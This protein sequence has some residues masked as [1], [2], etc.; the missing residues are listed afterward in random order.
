MVYYVDSIYGRDENDGC[1]RQTAFRTVTRINSLTLQGGDSVL[2]KAGGVYPGSLIPRREPGE[3]TV[4]F[5]RY[6]VGAPPVIV[7]DTEA[8]VDLLDFAHVELRNLAVTNPQ[9]LYGVR[10]CN[11]AGGETAHVHILGCSIYNVYGGHDTFLIQTGGIVITSGREKPGWYRDLLI[12][13]NHVYD[14]CRTGIILITNWSNRPWKTWAENEYVSDTENWW[15]SY[16]VVFRGNLIERPAGDA[17]VLIG[18]IRP[19]MEWNT[20][21]HVMNDPKPHCANAGIWPQ[22]TEGCVVQYNEVGYAHK[23]AGCDDAQGF[24]VD[25]SC[26]DTLV[27]YNYSHDN[28]G[29]FLLL[30]ELQGTEPY[31]YRGTVVR[32]NLSVNDGNVKGELIALVGPV[33][34]VTIENNTLYASGNVE[35]IVEVW[36]GEGEEQAKDVTIRNNLF[37]SNGKNN[38]FHLAR[39]ENFHMENNLYWGTHATP[40]EGEKDAV[41]ADP[42][43]RL[44]GSAGEGRLCAEAYVPLPGSP[45]LAAELPPSRPAPHDFFGNPVQGQ[46]YIGAFLGGHRT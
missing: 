20:A 14:V 19:L 9:G 22:S 13:D 44:D 15:P 18:A 33:R 40:P 30:C 10:V 17:M 11:N 21:Y 27:Q 7:G 28:E 32:N 31:G 38:Q 43:L 34:G 5:D 42:R 46:A 23:P 25:L 35:R 36:S 39:G 24:D 3:E 45:A 26:R 8:A 12:E 41:T 16:E 6:G 4:S 29:G 1:S 37:I 2:F